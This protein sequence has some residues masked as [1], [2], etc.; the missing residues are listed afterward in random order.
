MVV[1]RKCGYMVA[2]KKRGY[3]V[4]LRKRDSGGVEEDNVVPGGGHNGY[5][6]PG[7][8]NGRCRIHA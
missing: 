5:S 8:V 6:L 3:V 4:A 1:S 7:E 2:S